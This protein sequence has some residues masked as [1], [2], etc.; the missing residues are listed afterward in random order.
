MKYTIFN[1]P[2][3][4]IIMCENKVAS[5]FRHHFLVNGAILTVCTSLDYST[6]EVAVGWSVF[7]PNDDR[8]VRKVGNAIARS[9]MESCPITFR[10]TE[11]E[12]IVCDYISMKALLL[13][14]GASGKKPENC[15]VRE[16]HPS[17]IPDSTRTAIQFEM[18][19][20][21]SL[22]GMRVGLASI[23]S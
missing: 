4:E 12:P 16:D 8:W 10:L 19:H 21:L 3:E 1:E 9:R 13:I 17:A 15:A 5:R 7:N 20:I 18:I 6:H 2:K 23:D 22:L 14:I 11:C